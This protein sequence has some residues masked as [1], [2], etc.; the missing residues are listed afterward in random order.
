MSMTIARNFLHIQNKLESQLNG[1]TADLERIE[2]EAEKQMGILVEAE[3][4]ISS[5][6]K[7]KVSVEGLRDQLRV[8]NS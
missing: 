1:L 3:S 4:Q 7:L 6:A 2:A 5:L 8:I